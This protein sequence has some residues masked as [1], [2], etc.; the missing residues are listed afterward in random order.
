MQGTDYGAITFVTIGSWEYQP[1]ASN[2]VCFGD[3]REIFSTPRVS[4]RSALSFPVRLLSYQQTQLGQ[5]LSVQC[6]IPP[7]LQALLP[8]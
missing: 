3:F 1:E 4:D 5:R 7:S 2:L 8:G 6:L